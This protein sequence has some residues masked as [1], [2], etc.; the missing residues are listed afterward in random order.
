MRAIEK[1]CGI[2][3]PLLTQFTI[4]ACHY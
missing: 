2:S 4:C 1:Y 3:M